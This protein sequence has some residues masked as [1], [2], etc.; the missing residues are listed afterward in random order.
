VLYRV[1]KQDNLEA[2]T[3]FRHVY[4][5]GDRIHVSPVI[6]ASDQLSEAQDVQQSRHAIESL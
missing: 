6:I 3:V 2:P 5:V 4:Q 1:R